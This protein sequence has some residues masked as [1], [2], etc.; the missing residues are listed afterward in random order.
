MAKRYNE[1][2]NINE[3]NNV[4]ENGKRN[5][6]VAYGD[7]DEDIILKNFTNKEDC[8]KL[9][10]EYFDLENESELESLDD[11]HFGY[12]SEEGDKHLIYG[13]VG[14]GSLMYFGRGTILSNDDNEGF[15]DKIYY[16]VEYA[17]DYTEITFSTNIIENEEDVLEYI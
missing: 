17:D 1:Y 8:L 5:W 12:M 13:I 7:S 10:L 4:D 15:H 14:E 6:V 9:A 16:S 11:G 2:F 3:N